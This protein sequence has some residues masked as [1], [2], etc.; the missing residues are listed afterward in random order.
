VSGLSGQASRISELIAP[1]VAD[2]GFEL[3][4]VQLMRGATGRSQT[5]QVM[6]ERPDGTMKVDD[7]A[8]L[9]RAISTLLDVE[10]PIKGDYMLEVSSPGIDRPLVRFKDFETYAGFVAKLETA[11]PIEGRRKFRGQ[12]TGV[13]GGNILLTGDEGSYVIPFNIIEKAKLVLTD[14]LIAA[15]EGSQSES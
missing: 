2:L 6:A 13:D 15:H 5:L 4:R 9:S 11:E 8:K 3:I 7:C 1:V 12:L 14:E 10:D